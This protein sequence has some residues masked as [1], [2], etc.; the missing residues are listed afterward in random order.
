MDIFEKTRE[1][2]EM[3]QESELM[4]RAK[5]LEAQMMK[6]LAKLDAKLQAKV[7]EA[8]AELTKLAE[9][10][11]ACVKVVNEE[12]KA[13]LKAA[14]T[15]DYVSDKESYYVA[16]GDDTAAGE[17]SYPVRLA[18]ELNLKDSQLA[19][20]AQAGLR[21]EDIRAM[22]DDSYEGDAYTATLDLDAEAVKAEIAKADLITVAFGNNTAFTKAQLERVM[23]NKKALPMDWEALVGAK[24]AEYVAKAFTAVTDEVEKAGLD[25][26]TADLLT[27]ILEAYTYSYVGF[28]FNY[29]EAL[30]AIKAINPE[31]E[32]VIVG[33]YNPVEGLE[34]N[35]ITV[36]DYLDYL[37]ELTNALEAAYAMTV[38]NTTFVAAPAVETYFD[39]DVEAGG[40]ENVSVLDYVG[41]LLSEKEM[42]PNEN[43][44]EYI[45]DQI[46]N[47]GLKASHICTPVEKV[48][49]AT[50]KA[51]GKIEIVCEECGEVFELVGTIAKIDSAKLKYVKMKHNGKAKT[52]AVI[53]V[54]DAN[55]DVISSDSYDVVYEENSAEVGTHYVTFKFKGNYAGELKVAY[56]VVPGAVSSL[57]G[58]RFQYGNRVKLEWK[59]AEGATGYKVQY[60]S[61]KGYKYYT[62][63]VTDLDDVKKNLSKNKKYTFKVT[64]YFENADG[65]KL[66]LTSAAKS[67][68]VTTAKSKSKFVKKVYNPKVKKSSSKKVKV[69]WTNI[70]NESGYQISRSSKEDGTYIVKTV[71]T[72]KGKSTTVNAYAKGAK[73][74]T[75]YYYKVRAFRIVNGRYV[76]GNWSDVKA[77]TLK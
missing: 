67:V 77:Y 40:K 56:T 48:T 15:S 71:K 54:K 21:A 62:K 3:I 60:K 8:V 69:S 50:T 20:L 42:L 47:A 10:A 70:K 29:A 52:P 73:K 43:G 53:Y 49:P 6:Q 75:T 34:V 1:L 38:S 13:A 11:E 55:G 72:T 36:G 16:L 23:A 4:K 14:L 59:E 57:K 31:A 2:G 65:E 18:K 63:Y 17:K 7:N 32:V 74:G 19:N 27:A 58:Y 25:A 61:A 64:P 24:G 5:D 37:V 26:A 22:L 28:A 44:H 12:L 68:K 66:S 46:M 76:Y 35:E 30:N 39:A 9:K 41:A 45:K 51:D 33:M